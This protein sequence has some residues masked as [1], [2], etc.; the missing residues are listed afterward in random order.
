MIKEELKN[1][2]EEK[3][4]LRKFGL[5]VGTVLLAIGIVL[6]ITG[7]SLFFV[8]GGAGILLILLAII[9]PIFLK[10]ANKFWMTLAIIMGWFMSRVILTVLFYIVL[11]P[12]AFLLKIIGKDFLKLRA[13]KNTK[14]FWEKRDKKS[15]DKLDYERQF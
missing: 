15:T 10:P 6:Y 1:I 14:S 3:K 2:K 8:F 13:D 5:T 4:D 7:K 9:F 11:T 12:T